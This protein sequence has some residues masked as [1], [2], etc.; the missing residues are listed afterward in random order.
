MT[1]TGPADPGAAPRT[2][3]QSLAPGFTVVDT[4]ALDYR[5]LFCVIS[6]ADTVTVVAFDPSGDSHASPR[7]Y[8]VGRPIEWRDDATDEDMLFQIWR[9]GGVGSS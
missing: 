3:S 7:I 9:L 1:S 4:R 5:E 6:T 2:T 8:H